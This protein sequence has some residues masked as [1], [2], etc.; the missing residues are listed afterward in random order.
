MEPHTKMQIQDFPLPVS[1][2]AIPIDDT[3]DRED[4]AAFELASSL[5]TPS[6]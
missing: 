6:A 1:K 3:Q 4:P 5:V 2:I